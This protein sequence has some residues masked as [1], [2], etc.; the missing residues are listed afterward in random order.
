MSQSERREP[1]I[2]ASSER[3][4]SGP[5]AQPPRA[6]SQDFSQLEMVHRLPPATLVDR[7][8]FL[9][10]AH[11]GT[12]GRARRVRGRGLRERQRRRRRLAARA[13]GARRTRAGRAR[14]RRRGRRAR[15]GA[16]LRSPRGRLPRRRRGARARPRT[17]GHRRRGRGDRAPRRRGRVPRRAARAGRADRPARGHH[18]ERDRSGERVRVARELRGEPPRPRGHVHV[19]DPRRHAAASRVGT[20]RALRVRAAGEDS[21]P[22]ARCA[23]ACSPAARA[24]SSASSDC[25]PAWVVPTSPT[26]SSSWP[27]TVR[28]ERAVLPSLPRTRGRDG[29]GEDADRRAGGRRSDRRPQ[30]RERRA[31]RPPA[32]IGHRPA[33]LLPRTAARQLRGVAARDQLHT[34]R[35]VQALLLLHVPR[36][37]ART[38]R[39]RV[40][41]RARD[42][43]ATAPR[44]GD[45][46][47]VDVVLPPRRAH[48]RGRL[49]RDRAHAARH[50]HDLGLRELRLVRQPRAPA[51]AVPRALR[52]LRRD[53]RGR[54][55]AVRP[56]A[57]AHRPPVLRRPGGRRPRLR[58][59]GVA[60]RLVRPPHHDLPGRPAPRGPRPAPRDPAPRQGRRLRGRAHRA[61][62]HRGG[63]AVGAPRPAPRREQAPRLSPAHDLHEVEPD[64]PRRREAGNARH[65]RPLPRRPHRLRGAQVGRKA[66]VARHD[67]LRHRHPVVARSRSS[68]TPRSAR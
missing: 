22:T 28:R 37:R 49:L 15:Q 17:G 21:S 25:S 20:V 3:G 1:G 52:A 16:R 62:R 57:R 23:R 7:F 45:R 59:R 68:T 55:D 41:R 56:P 24:Q 11:R 66:G 18:T 67:G 60:A 64:L 47:A 50:L 40:R 29:S 42:D 2:P 8:D 51:R 63:R 30:R 44:D 54:F 26:V 4:P 12:A 38:A 19:P 61:A 10:R 34:R 27:A 58:H 36:H 32:G 48:D 46:G 39:H 35:L 6:G 14:R 53:R 65:P 33:R 13:P 9:P 5:A 31:H 43:L